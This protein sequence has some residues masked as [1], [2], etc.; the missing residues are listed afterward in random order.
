ML[1]ATESHSPIVATLT[2]SPQGI[3]HVIHPVH[4]MQEATSSL[5]LMLKYSTRQPLRT[6]K[7]RNKQRTSNQH[8]TA[9]IV[10]GV[11]LFTG[12]TFSIPT[13]FNLVP[14]KFI[15]NL[16]L[17]TISGVTLFTGVTFSIPPVFNLVPVK[18]T[19]NLVLPIVYGVTLFTGVTFS[20]QPVF[21]LVPVKFTFNLVLPIVCGVTLFTKVTISIPTPFNLVPVKFTFNLVLQRHVLQV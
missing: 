12:V 18:F 8:T 21:N 19:F 14:V 5:P 3:L 1:P 10:C 4:F 17:P 13:V 15:F 2:S 11:T 16:V 7:Q 20:I 9:P 6:A